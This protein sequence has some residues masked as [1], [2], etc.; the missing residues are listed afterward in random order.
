MFTCYIVQ[1]RVTLWKCR[2]YEIQLHFSHR[3]VFMMDNCFYFPPLVHD[4]LRF[5]CVVFKLLFTSYIFVVITKF[6]MP[7]LLLKITRSVFL[8]VR[9]K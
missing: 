6:N 3:I 2:A 9:Q 8:L 1:T 5:C 7:A 4:F